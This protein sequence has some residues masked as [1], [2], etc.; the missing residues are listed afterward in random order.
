MGAL[1]PAEHASGREKS[2]DDSVRRPDVARD[3][4]VDDADERNG[5]KDEGHHA[6]NGEGKAVDHAAGD[7]FDGAGRLAAK[8][9][10]RTLDAICGLGGP[11]GRLVT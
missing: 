2:P 3:Q 10:D 5:E 6:K 11:V 8:T 7:E 4:L 9:L 1:G